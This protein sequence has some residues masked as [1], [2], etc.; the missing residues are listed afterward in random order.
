MS[1]RSKP[2]GTY[3]GSNGI[4]L[5]HRRSLELFFSEESVADAADNG[6]C[7][8]GETSSALH[9]VRTARATVR[10]NTQVLLITNF[11][12]LEALGVASFVCPADLVTDLP[13]LPP[14]RRLDS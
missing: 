14:G 6:L 13:P 4:S 5:L 3:V 7:D 1:S 2:A 11:D 9:P 12:T 10:H 8:R